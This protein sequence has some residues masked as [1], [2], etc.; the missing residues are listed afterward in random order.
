MAITIDPNTNDAPA[1]NAQATPGRSHS[2]N[3]HAAPAGIR[4]ATDDDLLF[5]KHLAARTSNAVGFVPTGGLLNYVAAGCVTIT[6]ENDDEAGYLLARPRVAGLPFIRPIVQAAVCFDARRRRHALT[7][8]D[9]LARAA[10]LS[11]QL[12]LQCWCREELEANDF[13][14]AA[15]FIAVAR[16]HSGTARRAAC[17]L[18]RRPLTTAA[19]A[20]LATMSPTHR[21]FGPGGR[22]LD[23]STAVLPT[24]ELLDIAP[25]T[26]VAFHQDGRRPPAAAIVNPAATFSTAARRHAA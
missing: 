5:V 19:T 15:G 11:G 24:V 23:S 2:W 22:W 9:D 16:R 8:V 20:V 7:L 21:V 25:L 6:E 4:P 13:W 3:V 1:V 10:F 26:A 17:I 18:W 12:L 14:R